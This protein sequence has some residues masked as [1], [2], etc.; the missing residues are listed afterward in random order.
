MLHNNRYA[1]FKLHIIVP[2]AIDKVLY[3]IYYNIN[4]ATCM[5]H[6]HSR[7]AAN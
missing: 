7:Q 3:T 5:S 6:K 4:L 2:L 1:L